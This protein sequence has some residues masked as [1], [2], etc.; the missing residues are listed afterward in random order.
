V[1]STLATLILVP[2]L[3]MLVERM[4]SP[5]GRVLAVPEGA[6]EYAPN[7]RAAQCAKSPDPVAGSR[8]P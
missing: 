8:C 6:E 7:R 3:S 1:L 5:S 2:V 4:N